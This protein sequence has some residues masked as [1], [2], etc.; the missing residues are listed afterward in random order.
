MFWE[1]S[2]KIDYAGWFQGVGGILAVIGAFRIAN[3]QNRSLARERRDDEI[4]RLKRIYQLVSSCDTSFLLAKSSLQTPEAF[5]EFMDGRS[6]REFEILAENVARIHLKELP[7]II[8]NRF[9]IALREKLEVA[10][11]YMG[12]MR[13]LQ[14][15][16]PTGKRQMKAYAEFFESAEKLTEGMKQ[17]LQDEIDSLLQKII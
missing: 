6:P 8:V 2:C 17:E 12:Q 3:A 15:H 11:Y 10:V 4:E 16:T 7:N 9:C 5:R 1:A 14:S 13:T